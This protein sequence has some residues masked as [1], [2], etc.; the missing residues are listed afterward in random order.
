[1]R[2]GSVLRVNAAMEELLGA[3]PGTLVEQ[4]Q[5]FAHP[6][7]RL[8]LAALGERFAEIQAKGACEFELY[9]YRRRGDPLWVTVQGRA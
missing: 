4:I 1:V 3:E 6:S 5:L 2:D 9:M 8:L 7:D